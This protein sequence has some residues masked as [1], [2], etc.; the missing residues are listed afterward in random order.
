MDSWAV[1]DESNGQLYFSS[2]Q[3]NIPL[4]TFAVKQLLK[5]PE[6]SEMQQSRLALETTPLVSINI[7]I[8]SL[9]YTIIFAIFLSIGNFFLLAC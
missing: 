4:S 8:I 1:C 5:G 6:M 2:T 9:K 7:I 3:R